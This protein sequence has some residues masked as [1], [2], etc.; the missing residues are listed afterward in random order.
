MPNPAWMLA[1]Q[2]IAKTSNTARECGSLLEPVGEKEA[3]WVNGCTRIVRARNFEC[4][5]YR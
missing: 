1:E 4:F 3:V 5:G 2:H